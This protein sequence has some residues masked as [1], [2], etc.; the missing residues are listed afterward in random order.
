MEFAIYGRRTCVRLPSA[1]A[2]GVIPLS[3]DWMP[4]LSHDS[5]VA[6]L[7]IEMDF[8]ARARLKMDALKSA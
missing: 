6:R 4:I 7:Q 2:D 3:D 1:D 5:Q 8:L